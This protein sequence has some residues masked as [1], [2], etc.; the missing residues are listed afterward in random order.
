[1]PVTKQRSRAVRNALIHDQ[2]GLL[3]HLSFSFRALSK[4]DQEVIAL[5][6]GSGGRRGWTDSFDGEQTA[7]S[8][9]V[10]LHRATKRLRT[11]LESTLG[12][13]FTECSDEFFSSLLEPEA[14]ATAIGIRENPGFCSQPRR[15]ESRVIRVMIEIREE[16][17]NAE[18]RNALFDNFAFDRI[19]IS[20]INESQSDDVGGAFVARPR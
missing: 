8:L 7:N 20:R 10:R 18:A 12:G 11:R 13:E 4:S 6:A 16:D 19:S 9:R 3:E 5:Y 2:E 1:M 17:F 14:L 15:D